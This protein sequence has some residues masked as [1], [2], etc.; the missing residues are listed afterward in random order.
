MLKKYI[1]VFPDMVNINGR[2]TLNCKDDIYNLKYNS[3]SNTTN[4]EVYIDTQAI[5]DGNVNMV[6]YSPINNTLLTHYGYSQICE[7]M[8]VTHS[9]FLKLSALC[10]FMQ[11][12]RY[13]NSVFIK[14]FLPKGQYSL[15]SD[16]DDYSDNI[17]YTSDCIEPLDWQFIPT[18]DLIKADVNEGKLSLKLSVCRPVL[19]EAN[20]NMHINYAGQ[21]LP[22]VDGEQ[23]YI[24]NYVKGENAYIGYPYSRRKGRMIDI[25]RAVMLCIK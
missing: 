22:I 1:F 11:I 14:V 13:K 15:D 9:E 19:E 21:C 10:G 5:S 18:F 2:I 12:D 7:S 25:E 16:T 6:L 20:G 8:N 3:E 23:E 17:Y 4:K 24:F